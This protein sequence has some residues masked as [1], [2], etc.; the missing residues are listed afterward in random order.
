MFQSI[1]D[2][3][4]IVLLKHLIQNVDDF[5]R[6]CGFLKSDIFHLNKEFKT[7]LI[8]RNEENLDH[9][10]NEESSVIENILNK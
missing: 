3:S 1:P 10:K 8:E 6:E 5:L 7:I 4:K 2:Y 9:I